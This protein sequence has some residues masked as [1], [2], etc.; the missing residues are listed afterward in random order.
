MNTFR[1]IDTTIL[2]LYN[3]QLTDTLFHGKEY[4][5]EMNNA[6]IHD[7][8]IKYLFET[9]WFDAQFWCS[10]SGHPW[11][12]THRVLKSH[13][14]NMNAIYML[15]YIYIYIYI[16]YIYTYYFISHIYIDIPIPENC[17]PVP[18]DEGVATPTLFLKSYFSSENPLLC[19]SPR[20]PT[21]P[22]IPRIPS[23]GLNCKFFC[24]MRKCKKKGSS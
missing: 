2:H 18:T 8:I 5:H 21:G 19:H 13:R 3:A 4:F 11:S 22:G 1:G 23:V 10:P 17:R 7:A 9:K 12:T 14:S 15:I 6:S 24:L 16:Y 20:H